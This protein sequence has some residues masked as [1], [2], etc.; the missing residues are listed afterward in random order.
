[1][2]YVIFLIC[3]LLARMDKCVTLS[4]AGSIVPIYMLGEGSMWRFFPLAMVLAAAAGCVAPGSAIGRLGFSG[5]IVT[6]SVPPLSPSIQVTLPKHYGLGGLDPYFG[7]PED[8]GHRDQTV[9][10]Q[11]QDGKF[12]VDF[13]PVVYHVSVWLLP[14]LGAF[15]RH[16]PSPTFFVYFSDTPD[17][18]YLVGI[19]RGTFRYKVLDRASWSEKPADRAAWQIIHGEY[20]ARGAGRQAVWYLHIEAKRPNN[21]VEPTRALSGASGSP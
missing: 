9:T 14:P 5:S 20:S 17:E 12:S 19:D 18:V 8:Y 1:M 21:S 6:E 2:L 4:F 11:V 10:V 3:H 13:P 7:Q 16:P 15:P